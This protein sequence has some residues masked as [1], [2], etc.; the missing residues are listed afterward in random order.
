MSEMNLK[1]RLDETVHD[2]F[3]E[4][5]Y[6]GKY[7]TGQRIDPA[8]LA[9]QFSISRTPVVQ[10]LKQ[11]ANER[12]LMVDKGG[13]FYITVPTEK[14]V[15][16]VCEIRCLMEQYAVTLLIR[17]YNR[18]DLEELRKIAKE[19]KR[20][21]EAGKEFES[22]QYYREFQ[23][24]FIEKTGNSCLLETYHLVIYQYGG[25][26]YPLGSKLIMN[27]ELGDWHVKIVDYIINREEEKAK[28]TI[29]EHMEQCRRDILY[30][31]QQMKG[32]QM[33]ILN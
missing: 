14:M 2:M 33:E 27:R 28:Q 32:Q 18:E 22:V 23:K 9:V 16:D 13:K 26:R 11:L 31:M 10:A 5:L 12:V 15:N 1:K 6:S 25:I 7:H 24:K 30:Q 29:W 20:L 21:W 3:I 4:Q 19:S 8:E 17:N